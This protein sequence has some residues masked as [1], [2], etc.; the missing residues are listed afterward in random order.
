MKRLLALLA[1]VL[2]AGIARAEVLPITKF[3][4]LN[5]DDSPILI[6]ADET[7]DSQN[8]VTD[9]GPGLQGRKGF[10]Q[11]ST[12]PSSGLWEFPLSNGTRYIITKS[13]GR[14]KAATSSNPGAFT[15]SI[16]TVPTDRVT[17]ATALGD[18]FFFADTLNGLKY[19]NTTSVVVVGSTLTFSMLTT[20]KGR[21]AGAG[22]SGA[23]RVIYLSRYL[24]GT[25]FS[26]ET[27]PTDDGPSQ[28]TVAGALD[29]G[30]QALYG[31]FQDKLMWFKKN[32]FGAI[33]GSRR[34]NFSQRTFSDGIGVASPETIRD[35]DGL[36]RWLGNNHIIW[37][38]DGATF[39]KISEPI[40]SLLGSIAQGDATSRSAT[41]TSETDWEAGTQNPSAGFLDTTSVPG[42]AT[43]GTTSYTLAS[44]AYRTA[45]SYDTTVFVDTETTAG[46]VST[47]FPDLFS[48]LRTAGSG[49]KVVW[50]TGTSTSHFSIAA[51]SGK[52]VMTLASG[53]GNESA[54]VQSSSRYPVS[55]AGTTFYFNVST[56]PVAGS[57]SSI[58]SVGFIL[59]ATPG[60]TI[61]A[62]ANYTD[63]ASGGGPAFWFAFSSST[64]ARLRLSLAAAQN[65][66]LGADSART[67]AAFDSVG[68]VIPSQIAIYLTT[69]TWVVT[70]NGTLMS[71]GTHSSIVTTSSTPYCY[72]G[73]VSSTQ[74]SAAYAF[75]DFTVAP[76]T[77]TFTQ[78]ADSHVSYP[79]YSLFTATV[80]SSAISFNTQASSDDSSYDAG[81]S[82][83]PGSAITSSRK[84]YLKLK[85]VFNYSPASFPGT[86]QQLSDFFL[87]TYSTGT[88]VTTFNP[89]TNISA[90]GPVTFNQLSSG[91][92]VSFEIAA[93]AD[94]VF[95]SWTSIASGATPSIATN[96]YAG[97]RATFAVNAATQTASLY[98]ETISWTEGSTVRAASG[99]FNNRYWLSVALSSTSNNRIVLYDKNRNWQRYV[100][101]NADV[102]SL[103]SSALYFGNAGG[104]FQNEQGYTDNGS[105][106][107]AYY[108]TPTIPPSGID[109]YTTFTKL[110][111]TT[112]RSDSALAASFQVNGSTTTDYSL[113]VATMNA[114]AGFQNLKLPFSASTVQQGKFINMKFDVNGS[115]FWRIN[116]ADLY[117]TP[118]LD[119]E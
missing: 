81:V 21:L 31:S 46:S 88:L 63:P 117:Y 86:V 112:D 13:N 93:S 32:S 43:A 61:N 4:G 10:I 27:N 69:S 113:G 28:I 64:T 78:R 16:A 58:G 106:I 110:Y 76:Q 49:A 7:P 5:S 105:T 9:D 24:V 60:Q 8:V 73:I 96:T 66:S 52:L 42:T 47:T 98:D 100:G 3:G 15:I 36:L 26:L 83:S 41:K 70:G 25:D 92:T 95:S 80:T 72:L 50:S 119:P 77:F 103:Y 38:F 75:D 40:D 11:Y 14:L 20:W 109:K 59:N 1:L 118:G 85:S 74:T 56:Y 71:N 35:C 54:W 101:I 45:S 48:S 37:E 84:R 6:G 44:S 65:H 99:Y 22:V 55:T 12:E 18:K 97:I 108:R 39:K 67:G 19:W 87:G 30:I 17:V 68:V 62:A 23:E 51:T 107:D 111:V 89:G 104:I 114:T 79:I 90:W 33:Y 57:G 116:E 115:A 2:G 94:G 91:A 53:N 82:V 29:E 34:S 102:F